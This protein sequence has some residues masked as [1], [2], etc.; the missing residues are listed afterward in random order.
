MKNLRKKVRKKEK[1]DAKQTK[2]NGTQWKW[3]SSSLPL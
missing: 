3:K 2:K 1:T